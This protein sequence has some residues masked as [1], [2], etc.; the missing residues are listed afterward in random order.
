ME[1]KE[2]IGSSVNVTCVFLDR[3]IYYTGEVVDVSSDG[4]LVKIIDINKKVIIL[5]S[6]AIKQIKLLGDESAQ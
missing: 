2:L 1:L 3:V 5:N 4:K 6:D